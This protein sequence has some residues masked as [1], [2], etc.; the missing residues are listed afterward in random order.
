MDEIEKKPNI[1]ISILKNKGVKKREVC[2]FK[3]KEFE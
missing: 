2:T 1:E 3:L